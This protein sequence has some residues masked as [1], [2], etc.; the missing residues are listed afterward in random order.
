MPA[1][2]PV[3]AIPGNACR[4]ACNDRA[5]F[6]VARCDEQHGFGALR[7]TDKG[8][9]LRINA[10]LRAE[11]CKRP[12]EQLKRNAFQGFLRARRA[13]ICELQNAEAL[14]LQRQRHVLYAAAQPTFGSAK[15][16][17]GRVGALSRGGIVVAEEASLFDPLPRGARVKH[18][19]FRQAIVLGREEFEHRCAAHQHGDYCCSRQATF[20]SHRHAPY[21]V[22]RLACVRRE[23][24]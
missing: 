11:P 18:F 5:D 22:A 6:R 13:K 3:D 12:I 8:K 15:Q 16:Q 4:H 1:A 24:Q 21:A 19:D 14:A 20:P 7:A 10:R 23:R 2:L 17:Y 9:A